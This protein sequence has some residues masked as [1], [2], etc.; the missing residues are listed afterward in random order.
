MREC[1][2]LT[3]LSAHSYHIF[4]SLPFSLFK[5]ILAQ[6]PDA[7]EIQFFEDGNWKPMMRKENENSGGSHTIHTIG[8]LVEPGAWVNKNMPSYQYRKSHSGDKAAVRSSYLQNGICYT[9]K[10]ASLYWMRAQKAAENTWLGYFC[11]HIETETKW[12][13]LSWKYFRLHF[14]EWKYINYD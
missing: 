4:V 13:P 6:S 8:R 2:T 3:L 1:Q 5:E 9:G 7:N 10:M 14:L 12:L 11:Q